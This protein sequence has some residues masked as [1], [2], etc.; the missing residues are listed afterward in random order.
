LQCWLIALVICAL[1]SSAAAA[2]AANS[3]ADA[4]DSALGTLT[5]RWLL[6]I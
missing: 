4:V 1:R 3:N 5:L 6:A 2:A